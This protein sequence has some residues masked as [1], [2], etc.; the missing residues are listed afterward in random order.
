MTTKKRFASW[1]RSMQKRFRAWK[2]IDAQL[3]KLHID[4]EVLRLDCVALS[5]HYFHW[6][7]LQSLPQ[8]FSLYRCFLPK[9]W[10]LVLFIFLWWDFNPSAC[11][12]DLPLFVIAYDL[13][14]IVIHFVSSD[15]FVPNF[16]QLEVY[17]VWIHALSQGYYTIFF[18]PAFWCSLAGLYQLGLRNSPGD[19]ACS[20][21]SWAWR[22][23]GSPSI[24]RWDQVRQWRFVG[25]TGTE[26][27]NHSELDSCIWNRCY[28]HGCFRMGWWWGFSIWIQV[29]I[30][31]TYCCTAE[32]WVS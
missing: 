19:E 13:W 8:S 24:A 3:K 10:C 18:M 17:A 1:R 25:T 26:R 2:R 14:Y 7:L 22:S 15:F 21:D 31:R 16:N 29:N 12:D 27:V 6:Y 11:G 30:Q 20:G 4:G 28:R 23:C 5:D 32:L 9:F